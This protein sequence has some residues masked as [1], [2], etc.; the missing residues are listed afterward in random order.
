MTADEYFALGET[1]ERYELIDG[2]VHMSPRPTPRHQLVMLELSEQLSQARRQ[3]ALVAL[4][5]VDLQLAADLVYEL[6]FVVYAA[7]RVTKL[8]TRLTLPPDLVIEVLSPGSRAKDLVTKLN[9]YHR[10]GV[11]EYWIIDP[12]DG[13]V[14]VCRRS[15]TGFLPVVI[16]SDTLACESIPGL[17]ID[18]RPIRAAAAHP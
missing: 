14:R 3:L 17:V 9:D 8:P 5:D 4:P 1:D 2:V 10:F 16:S 12:I 13:S 6:D 11:G 15:S 7:G 18:L